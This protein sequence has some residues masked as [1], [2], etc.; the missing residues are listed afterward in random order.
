MEDAEYLQFDL[1]SELSIRYPD[2]AYEEISV[3][4]NINIQDA[5][6][7]VATKLIERKVSFLA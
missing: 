6:R 5:L 1:E 4:L 2:I 7:R 3:Q